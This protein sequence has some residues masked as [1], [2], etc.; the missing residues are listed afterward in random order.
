M[1]LLTHGVSLARSI[2]WFAALFLLA[3]IPGPANAQLFP[4]CSWP[5]EST[6]G[7]LTNAFFPDTNATYW[8]MPLDTTQWKAMVIK[9]EYP[10]ARF[11]SF[12]TYLGTGAAADSMI[13]A[14]IAP[15]PGGTNPFASTN[16]VGPYNY[17]VTIGGVGSA[18]HLQF[19]GTRLAFVIYRVYVPDK[20]LNRMGGV[21]LPS[22]SVVAADGHT[23]ALEPCP[24]A[25]VT[26]SPTSLIRFFQ[27]QGFP[28][29][30]NTLQAVATGDL[31]DLFLGDGNSCNSNSPSSGAVTFAPNSTNGRFRPF[32][33][34]AT[35]Y[36]EVQN[37]CFQ[38]GK[39]LVVRGKAAVF[40]DTYDGKSVFEPAIA[41]AIQL[42]YWSMCNNDQEVPGPVVACAAD[43]A[44]QLDTQQFYTYVVSDDM[45]PPSWIPPGATWLPW[46]E[47]NIPKTLI[48][49]NTSPSNFTLAG[50]YVPQAVF[51]D[52]Q[53]LIVGGWQACFAPK[54]S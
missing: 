49:R 8:M 28:D 37:L 7:G 40:P 15:D 35:T 5:I 41:G 29:T 39:V 34:P 4:L 6:G 52:K 10:E 24:F 19:G 36:V 32:P 53:V 1:P 23:R 38:P 54:A 45:M 43:W 25:N 13:D 16:A 21:A 14:D 12:V 48:F 22:V 47:T 17:T 2:I 33:N 11:F 3:N 44:A 31:D 20:G 26:A 50:D 51:C 18:N 9:G 27:S 30:A 46:G 42:R